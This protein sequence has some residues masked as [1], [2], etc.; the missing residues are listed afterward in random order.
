MAQ[1]V[2]DVSID[3]LDKLHEDFDIPV[4]DLVASLHLTDKNV[5]QW[6]TTGRAPNAEALR[7]LH[8]LV[9]L[10]DG[11]HGMFTAPKDVHEW[12]RSELRYLQWQTPHQV[13]REGDPERAYAAF[14]AL[15]SGIFL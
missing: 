13:I 4:A 2:E 5:R 15:A 9:Q 14:E 6:S 8:T 7:H 1:Q 10:S 11:L 3:I 12:I